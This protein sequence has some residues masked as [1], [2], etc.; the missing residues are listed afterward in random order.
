MDLGNFASSSST[1]SNCSSIYS[2]DQIDELLPSLIMNHALDCNCFLGNSKTVC[3]ANFNYFNYNYIIIIII[4]IRGDRHTHRKTD[5]HGSP[6]WHSQ[7]TT[8]LS[9]TSSLTFT[10]TTF[11]PLNIY[12]TTTPSQPT[13]PPLSPD[14]SLHSS[15]SPNTSSLNLTLISDDDP[16]YIPDEDLIISEGCATNGSLD[17]LKNV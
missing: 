4:I 15:P 6:T 1:A 13:P 10:S 7:A 17:I 11:T 8:P 14:L 9:T 3:L 12:T 5:R 16:Q 2:E